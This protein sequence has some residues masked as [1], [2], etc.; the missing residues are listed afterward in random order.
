M[1]ITDRNNLLVKWIKPSSENEQDRQERALHMVSRAINGWSGFDDTDYIVY[2]KG[3][4]YNRTNVRLDSD[5]DIVVQLQECLYYD[6]FRDVNKDEAIKDGSYAGSWTPV[7]W[8]NEVV[9]ALKDFLVKKTLI[10]MA[11]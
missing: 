11:R 1:T 6:Y 9:A 10:P 2:P 3:S 7:K 8:R 4:Y 5:V